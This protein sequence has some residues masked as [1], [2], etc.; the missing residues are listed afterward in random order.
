MRG[1]GTCVYCGK[2][3]KLSREHIIP[4]ALGGTRC[5]QCVCPTC[6]NGVLSQLDEELTQRSPISLV[7][8]SHMGQ[9]SGL[10]WDVDH[11]ANHLL[12]EAHADTG[13][14]TMR[15][16]PQIIF[17]DCGPI[18]IVAA[19]EDFQQCGA[20]GVRT[21]LIDHV[22]AAS[23][24]SNAGRS[25]LVPER[26]PVTIPSPYRCPP[27]VFA[28][29]RIHDFSDG[30]HFICRYLNARDQRKVLREL[31]Q[32]ESCRRFGSVQIFRGSSLPSFQLGLVPADVLRALM[33]VA[34]NLLRHVCSRTTVDRRSFTWVVRVILGEVPVPHSLLSQNGFTDAADIAA[35][36][37]PAASHL[38]RVLHDAGSWRVYFSFFTGAVGAHVTFPGPSREPWRT[39]DIRIPLRSQDWR[40]TKTPILLP[41]CVRTEWS[42]LTKILPSLPLRNIQSTARHA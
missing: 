38:I 2:P 30:M 41:V 32:W 40:V 17:D 6:N 36:Q 3:G 39:A 31:S 42:D 7:L 14:S 10:T 19:T 20:D 37:C 12:L 34:V 11:S 28:R 1:H 26:I 24:T 9:S 23:R 13:N 21:T 8:P 33:K 4:K 22:L 27:R 15:L 25:R 16:W 18:T 5:I 35:L 29:R